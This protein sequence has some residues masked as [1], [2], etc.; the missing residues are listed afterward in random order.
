MAIP[1]PSGST[2]I[3]R[4]PSS[5]GSQL[6]NLLGAVALAVSDRM[7]ETIDSTIGRSQSGVA[8][9]S[10]LDQFLDGPTVERLA[11]VLGISQSGV[12]RLVDR[13]EADGYVRR[14]PGSDARSIAI[15]PTG[16]G[17][18]TAGRARQLRLD[19]L[20]DVLAPLDEDERLVM[21]E[22]LGRI[23]A[24]L[25]REPGAVRWTCRLCDLRACGR[26]EGRCPVEQEARRRF[27]EGAERYRRGVPPKGEAPQ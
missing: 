1:A 27:G 18:R 4:L 17:R 9:L 6:A 23:L 24:G 22:L 16:R 20:E 3:S 2:S 21:A 5:S 25:M 11:Q 14:S 26:A 10:A 7:A 8:A 15:R 19:L 12:V 13:L